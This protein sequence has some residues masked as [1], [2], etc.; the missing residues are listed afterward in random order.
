V[1]K[2]LWLDDES[3][4]N[5]GQIQVAEFWRHSLIRHELPFGITFLGSVD[6]IPPQGAAFSLANHHMVFPEFK[7]C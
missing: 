6:E 2:G 5:V 4:T 7:G 1:E 3:V